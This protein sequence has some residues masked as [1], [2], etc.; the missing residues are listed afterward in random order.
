MEC[1][2]E[3]LEILDILFNSGLIRGRK[4]FEDDILHLITHSEYCSKE[5]LLDLVKRY[6]QV[7]GISVI[8]GSY[9]KEKPIKVFDDGSY[10]VEAIYGVEYDIMNNDSLIGRMI[11]YEDRVIL[12]FGKEEKEYKMS[13]GFAIRALKDH[14]DKYSTLKEFIL[15][16]LK[17]LE[18]NNDERV[19]QWLK[20]F[21][22]SK[23]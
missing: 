4:V 17:F 13:K 1:E 16:Y 10:V 6:L 14:L 19:I 9:Y 23:P 3:A 22:S 21:L 12:E 7:L 18:E 11:F 8:K 5:E 2:K 20:N 15:N